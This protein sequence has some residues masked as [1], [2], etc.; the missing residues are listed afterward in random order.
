M[1][2]V[3]FQ[4]RGRIWVRR[5]ALFFVERRFASLPVPAKILLDVLL[6]KP[7]FTLRGLLRAGTEIRDALVKGDLVEEA[8]AGRR[9]G[10]QGG[11]HPSHDCNTLP[12]HGV[13][14]GAGTGTLALSFPSELR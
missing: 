9:G 6:L 11:I 3:G 13:A 10:R 7:M 8:P 5:A 1:T 12:V 2:G 14:D 4:C